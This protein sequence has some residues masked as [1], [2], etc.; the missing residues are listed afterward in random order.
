MEVKENVHYELVPLDDDGWDIR[1]LDGKFEETV[2][3]DIV[4]QYVEKIDNFMF[5][6]KIRY[7]PD[8][9]LTPDNVELQEF[10]AYTITSLTKSEL[11]G[12]PSK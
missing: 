3:G 4:L 2:F 12:P 6:F 5:S 7:S 8:P 1:I 11:L 10:V 9:D